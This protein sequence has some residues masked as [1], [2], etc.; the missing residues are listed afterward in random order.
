MRTVAPRRALV[1]G[2]AGQDGSYLAELLL[3]AGYEVFGIVR[4][5]P[6]EGYA[7]LED[8]RDRLQLRQL[9]LLDVDAVT[10]VVAEWSPHEIYNL[11]SSSFVPASWEQPVAT[12]EFAAVSVTVLLEAIRLVDPEI[13]L[14]QASS[15]EIF[16]QPRDVPQTERT[17][18]APLSPYGVGKACGHFLVQSYRNR[19]R[20]H[21][22]SGILYNHESPRRPLEFLPRKVAHTA[23][24]IK[25]GLQDELCLGDMNA[26]R[27][28]GYAGDY[29]RAMWMML[30]QDEPD[31]Y[32]I[33]TGEPHTV[34]EL[35]EAAFDHVGLDWAEYVRSDDSLR[36]DAAER[37]DVV[38][39]AS[40]AR[41][42]FGWGPTVD[43][44]KL[45]ALMVD[46]DLA[47]LRAMAERV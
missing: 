45:V 34:L 21:A 30:Q 27:D 47:R 15:S 7:N 23:A 38:G 19:Y 39:D 5:E 28:W 31:D 40:K 44:E 3:D 2:T 20:L 14:Y 6:P 42:R 36:R 8:V 25:L 35:V 32:V 37:H 46:A 16:G 9:D 29:V 13:R 22:S 24:A 26:S 18:L 1:T 43:F 4:R 41:E 33:A 12:A 10:N 17:P 11:A